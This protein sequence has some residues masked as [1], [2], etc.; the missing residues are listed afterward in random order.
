MLLSNAFVIIQ[1]HWTAASFLFTF[2]M[3]NEA[4]QFNKVSL[5]EKTYE[6]LKK[7]QMC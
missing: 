4:L 1:K 6:I 3:Y 2:M 7:I 5:N